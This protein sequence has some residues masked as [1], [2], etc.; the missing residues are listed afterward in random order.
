MS[1][2]LV[3]TIKQ[4]FKKLEEKYGP[5]EKMYIKVDIHE[6]IMR[7]THTTEMSTEY[8]PFA[9]ETL[10]LMSNH[11]RV[12][13]ILWT[14]T[15]YDTALKYMELF[16]AKG[17]HFAHLNCNPEIA[18]PE[19]ADFSMKFF[20]NLII[21]DKAGFQAEV[22]WEPLH[23]YFELLKFQDEVKKLQT[24]TN[25]KIAGALM[26][27]FQYG[28]GKKYPEPFIERMLAGEYTKLCQL[29]GVI[30]IEKSEVING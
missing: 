24:E 1:Y 4:T 23:D 22:D 20:M 28:H 16:K 14:S 26:S 30:P 17:I 10:Q 6:T 3:K 21:D 12:C 29:W 18:S 9:V 5:D 8:Y 13:L 27:G 7:P 15:L 19:Y 25:A 11:P 2:R